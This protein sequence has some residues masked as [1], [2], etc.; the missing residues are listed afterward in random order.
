[1]SFTK[2]P[3]V[4]DFRYYDTNL[5]RENCYIY[6]GDTNAVSG[7]IVDPIRNPDGLMSRWCGAAFVGKVFFALN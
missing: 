1:L 5:S 7:G 2:S 3:F 4:L 6:T